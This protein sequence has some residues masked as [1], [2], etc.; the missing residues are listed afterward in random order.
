MSISQDGVQ[1]DITS[2]SNDMQTLAAAYSPE[3]NPRMCIFK[4]VAFS[5]RGPILISDFNGLHNIN[6]RTSAKKNYFYFCNSMPFRMM[7]NLDLQC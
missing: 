6:E 2:I 1:A 7:P 4:Q 3:F 5:T